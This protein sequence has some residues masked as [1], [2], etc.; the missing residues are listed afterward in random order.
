MR[1]A[2][3]LLALAVPAGCGPKAPPVPAPEAAE[4]AAVRVLVINDTY[5]IEGDVDG[6]RGGLARVRTL[7]SR[8]EAEH[9][10][11]LVLHAGDLLFP[12]FLS[13]SFEGAQMVDVLG[14]LDGDAGSA[15]DRL[16]VTF[17]NH[18]FDKGKAKHAPL[19]DARI[20]ESGFR[21]VSSNIE[22]SRGAD[23][24]ALI[25]ADNLVRDVIVDVGGVPV[26]VFGITLPFTTP[27][28]VDG[29]ADPIET[30]R[31]RTADLRARGAALVV[32]LTHQDMVRDRALLETL[33][34]EGPDLV[35]GG[36]EHARQDQVVDGRHIVKADADA[37]S[38][39]VV[40]LRRV[41]GAVQT[42]V[43]FVDLIGDT[44][45]EDPS[46]AAAVQGWID[47]QDTGFCE[48]K[49]GEP[50]GCL[51]APLSRAGTTLVASEL[52]I[53]RF[54]TNLGDWVADRMLEGWRAEGVQVAFINAGAL[55]INRDIAA[56]SA[57]T[58]REVEELLPY[59]SATQRLRL[60]RDALEA[61]L[62]RSVR[63]WTGQGHWLQ[64]A[65]IAFRHDPETAAVSDLT[66][67]TPEGP[68]RLGPDES[69]DA[70]SVT[71]L[72]TPATGQ[73]GYTMIRPEHLV[74]APGPEVKQLVLDGLV[75]AGEA[76]IA[77]TVEGRVCNPQR[78]GPCLV[79][80][81]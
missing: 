76:G 66:L 31:S 78:P 49:L 70:V 9:G 35:A 38:A 6:R 48:D 58:R 57:I 32:G 75:A 30:A 46:V 10:P 2:A 50:A 72:T 11:V 63:D 51:D 80:A 64:V 79:V 55:R 14:L 33:G 47:K 68:R 62:S 13:R 27:A 77:P 29:Y 8:I 22:W 4:P 74:G 59:P 40:T 53:R 61:V 3:A 17:G 25:D 67:L 24:A 7:R 21:W 1:R 36:H 56:G 73:D 34:D 44:V 39:A 43:A 42:D 60:D 41:A 69:V 5:R 20:E 81:P 16:L 18:E 54:E 19:L 37:F 28:Y 12:S 15:D 52:D 45:P 71:F 65:G 23:G 26:G